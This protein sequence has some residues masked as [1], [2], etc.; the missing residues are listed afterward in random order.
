MM[1]K[2]RGLVFSR[3]IAKLSAVGTPDDR[4]RG[5]KL[6]EEPARGTR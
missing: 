4:N 1:G 6:D 2:R 5:R 3:R